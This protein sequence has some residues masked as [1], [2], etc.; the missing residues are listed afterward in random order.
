MRLRWKKQDIVMEDIS[1]FIESIIE[2]NAKVSDNIDEFNGRGW[3]KVEDS[4][5]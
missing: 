3:T 4:V 5:E 2:E 1:F